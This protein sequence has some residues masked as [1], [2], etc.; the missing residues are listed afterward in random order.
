MQH[1]YIIF[2]DA[3]KKY[4]FS[5]NFYSVLA[6]NTQPVVLTP[7]DASHTTVPAAQD[8]TN[9]LI[10]D[11]GPS[12]HEELPATA[13]LG[14]SAQ[15]VV[16]GRNTANERAPTPTAT[17][18]EPP[19][20]WNPTCM[21][22]YSFKCN[23]GVQREPGFNL[24]ALPTM[25]MPYPPAAA[26]LHLQPLQPPN[27]S[28]H[29]HNSM[30]MHSGMPVLAEAAQRRHSDVISAFTH[31]WQR[32][33]ASSEAAPT[34]MGIKRSHHEQA[35]QVAS[36]RDASEH[37]P[38]AAKRAYSSNDTHT[39]KH[40]RSTTPSPALGT[41]LAPPVYPTMSE[42]TA[43][44]GAPVLL[45]PASRPAYFCGKCGQAK[46]GH[47]CTGWRHLQA[48]PAATNQELVGE[49]QEI[50][51]GAAETRARIAGES[52]EE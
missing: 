14:S 24:P 1:K 16:T 6:P 43:D 46:R 38:P 30:H 27:A 7:R 21:Y 10:I 50:S 23:A 4:A 22:T 28:T 41:L 47:V 12:A 48:V 49:S 5:G 33:A 42:S 11:E 17:A 45:R 9:M 29:M 52:A 15:H 25:W 37:A 2:N 36:N 32:M 13:A 31:Q 18:G 19:P 26:M 39:S 35:I 3:A 44:S 51:A 34:T 40:A 20:Q 8:A